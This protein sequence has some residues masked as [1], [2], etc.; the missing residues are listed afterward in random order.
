MAKIKV[1]SAYLNMYGIRERKEVIKAVERFLY[2]DFFEDFYLRWYS[3][4][5]SYI[6]KDVARRNFNPY[7]Y[8]D[9][10]IDELK[11][12]TPVYNTFNTLDERQNRLLKRALIENKWESTQQEITETLEAKGDFFSYW[13][14]EKSPF[15]IKDWKKVT[16]TDG[17]TFWEN[18]IPKIVVLDSENMVDIILD[19]NR[20]P[21]KYIYKDYY[22]HEEV[23]DKGEI[24]NKEPYTIT[25]VFEKGRIL[26][27][28]DRTNK[29]VVLENKE[30]EKDIIRIIHIPS[31]KKRNEKFSE[32]QATKYID[33]CLILSAIT[34]D[35]RLINKMSASPMLATND[36]EWIEENTHVEPGGV[37]AFKTLHPDIDADHKK[38]TPMIK[39]LEITNHLQTLKDELEHV[40]KVLY[41]KTAL[42]R[43]GLEEILGR[44]D[45][46]R[47]PSQ[48]RISLENK[49]RKYFVNTNEGMRNYFESILKYNNAYKKNMKPIGF[50]E[51]VTFVN[52]SVFDKLEVINNKLALGMTTLKEEW[53]K[54]GLTEDEI[55]I[56]EER[57]AEEFVE[58]N[59][60]IQV[61]TNSSNVAKTTAGAEMNTDNKFKQKTNIKK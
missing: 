6:S 30:H 55:K 61:T 20:T 15:Q 1:K 39:F 14:W 34:S 22:I 44:S 53:L 52:G 56:R 5:N 45:S 26:V 36:V 35:Y 8:M 51:P 58:N 60:D 23:N 37:Y 57:I 28:D 29:T 50:E 18:P 42:T 12:L 21:I 11:M 33:L 31:F 49:F 25:K 43:E 4:T 38:A 59:K 19:N 27:T 41:K 3:P 47:V 16:L 10:I 17:A 9:K 13:Y 40:D 7:G 2:N 48:I 46:S 24:I 54:Q 32:I